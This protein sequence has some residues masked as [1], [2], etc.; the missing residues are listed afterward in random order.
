MLC[1]VRREEIVPVLDGKIENKISLFNNYRNT[2]L[3]KAEYRMKGQ[4]ESREKYGGVSVKEK[5]D[6]K[7]DGE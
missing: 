7:D 4:V 6:I 1:I 3:N 2:V 5:E